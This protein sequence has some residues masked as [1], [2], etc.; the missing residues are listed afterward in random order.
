L[1]EL[2]ADYLENDKKAKH[3]D[4]KLIQSII[5][6][7]GEGTGRENEVSMGGTPH[8]AKITINFA[9]FLFRGDIQ[10]S[11]LLQKIQEELPSRFTADIEI[12]AE[13]NEDGPPQKDPIYIEVSGKKDY[14]EIIAEAAKIKTFL[15][16]KNPAGVEKLK[17]NVESNRPEIPLIVDRDQV[18]KLNS[19]TM[20][21]GMAIRKALL[22]QDIA[23][24][25][26][27]EDTYD[28]V[29]K[30]DKQNRE[31]L[32]ALLDQKL[33]FRNNTGQLLRIPIR[34]VVY[35]P[36]DNV[37]YSAVVR[38]NQ[39]PVVVVSSK[40][41]EGYNANEVVE[42]L[43]S[44]MKEYETEVGLPDGITYRFAG[45]QDEQ[46]KEMAFL[47][48]A[49][50]IAVFLIMLIIVTQ[51]NSF[52]TPAIILTSVIF[53]LIGV[54]LGLVLSGMSFVIIMTMIGIISLAGVVVNNAIVLIDY[55]NLL[56]Q[57]KREALGLTEFEQLPMDEVV[58]ATIEGGKTR[59]RPVLLTAITTV[60][61]LVPLAVGFNIDF[62][63]L[64]AEYDPKI[65]FGGDNNIFFS[66]MSWTIIYGLTFA[67]FL[68]LVIVPAMYLSLYR[69]KVWLY[70]IAGWKMR[71]NL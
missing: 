42:E 59:L 25:S 35:P 69:F 62:F 58:R 10:T 22:G 44:F 1:N 28:I 66:P 40:N 6:Q 43:K 32:D 27:G 37:S 23:T 31:D 11:D 14:Q 51:F 19:S 61:G 41:T 50:L 4:E 7:V 53:S 29:V 65:Y 49:L 64:L 30:F 8:K 15:D 57:E 68:T 54:F 3:P 16:R 56:R 33:I 63:S 20:A 21:V 52:S 9:E 13:K 38:K 46:E 71:S 70:R 2:L 45:Q 26:K 36:Q 47:S 48:K 12:S 39:T 34:S 17:M 18:R 55:T 60:L 67:T 24:Y 5:S